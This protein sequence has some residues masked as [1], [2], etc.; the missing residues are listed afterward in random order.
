MNK[1]KEAYSYVLL[2]FNGISTSMGYLKQKAIP[3]EEQ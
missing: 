3:V 1:L 2:L